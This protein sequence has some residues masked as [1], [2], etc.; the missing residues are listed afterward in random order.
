MSST[1][2]N[3][4][5]NGNG[6]T[7]RA[8]VLDDGPY[9]PER[10][11]D[12]AG[13]LIAR[14]RELAHIDELLWQARRG[15][16][17]VVA[18]HGEPGVGKTVLV[19]AAVA[20]ATEF[21]TVQLRGTSTAGTGGDP[22]SWPAP[23]GELASRLEH[24]VVEPPPLASDRPP[25]DSGPPT[26]PPAAAVEAVASGLRRMTEAANA[27]LLVTVDDCQ[28]LPSLFVDALAGGADPSPRRP[29]RADPGLAG[30]AAPRRLPAHPIRCAPTPSRRAHPGAGGAAH[31]L[32]V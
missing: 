8:P 11:A 32:P 2:E 15:G 31:A 25:A 16:G 12:E 7:H 13:G 26:P 29:G 17:G 19:E 18:L 27:P 23:L 9:R 22:L 21:R 1:V 28:A 30:L 5:E 4:I 14:S 10:A 20:R 24:F 6:G 3:G